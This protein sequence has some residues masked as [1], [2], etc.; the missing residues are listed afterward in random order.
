MQTQAWSRYERGTGCLLFRALGR[1][2]VVAMAKWGEQRVGEQYFSAKPQSSSQVITLATRLRGCEL[3]LQTDRG[4]FSR[5]GVD[6]GTRL[7]IE[8]LTLKPGDELLDLGCGYGP[9]GLAVAVSEPD[10]RVTMVDV[11][12]RAVACALT[13]AAHCGVEARVQVI[14]SDGVSGLPV[15]R[16]YTVIALNPPIRA[17][18]ATVYRLFREACSRLSESGK[19]YVVIQKKQGADSAQRYLFTLFD[20]VEIVV[21]DGGYRVYRCTGPKHEVLTLSSEDAII[22]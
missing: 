15:H 21:R 9:V 13:N 14:C 2:W 17:G 16:R 11:N 18:K 10:V 20:S 4:V 7:L 19:L 3:K 22:E 8:A 6:F 12:E 1:E 5:G